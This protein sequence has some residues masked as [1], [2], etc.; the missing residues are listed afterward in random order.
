MNVIIY[1]FHDQCY[2]PLL[3]NIFNIDFINEI[4]Y[5]G[6]KDHTE[7]LEKNIHIFDFGMLNTCKYPETYSIT[8]LD[9]RI[10]SDFYEC[11]S[12]CMKMFD[13]LEFWFPMSYEKR[14][15]YY[16]THL[17]FWHSIITEYNINC[18]ISSNFPHEIYDFIIYSIIKKRN[19]KTLC[20]TQTEYLNRV[21]F[22]NDIFDYSSFSENI[23]HDKINNEV[24]EYYNNKKQ[25]LKKYV[26]PFYMKKGIS[27]RGNQKNPQKYIKKYNQLAENPDY[28]SK[29]IYIP[30]HY[31]P[32]MTTSPMAKE[33]VSQ[34]L[35][36]SILD[37][38][39][40]NDITIF[41][42]EHPVQTQ[43]GRNSLSYCKFKIL[44]KFIKGCIKRI[45]KVIIN[46]K[47][48]LTLKKEISTYISDF[49][50]SNNKNK[51]LLSAYNIKTNNARIKF[52]KSNIDSQEL[53]SNSIAVATCTGTAAIEALIKEKPVLIFGN[54]FY[55]CAPGV[56]KI[57]N[58]EDMKNAYEFIQNFSFNENELLNFLQSIY[59][60]TYSL[61]VDRYYLKEINI[62][63]AYNNEKLFEIIN[64]FLNK[65]GEIYA[66]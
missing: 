14:R 41:V 57:K 59:N 11:E 40:P 35:V 9:Q 21:I 18:Y 3:K 52:I 27:P 58:N 24:I 33:Y 8:P 2:L 50:F 49:L 20:S 54:Y 65:A 16:L 46:P 29:Y 39:L 23:T 25:I 1:G 28:N 42:K 12:I 48:I 44:L 17:R 66:E 19:G 63:I 36:I 4:F 60:N 37:Y 55:D 62:N 43:I 34:D 51:I 15:N 31:Q 56:K 7:F 32:E 10:I 53:I 22:V 6:T 47:I 30:L 61:M 64:T 26:K 5:I 38:Y 13:R 45:F